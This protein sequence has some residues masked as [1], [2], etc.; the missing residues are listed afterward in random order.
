MPGKLE[1][2]PELVTIEGR[3]VSDNKSV[4]NVIFMQICF[5]H[6]PP[7]LKKKF[8]L[9]FDRNSQADV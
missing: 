3:Y 5:V 6:S 7:H 2:T 8:Y 4:M 9:V 1:R